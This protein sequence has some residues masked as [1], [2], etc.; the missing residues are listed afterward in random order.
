VKAE[1]LIV[2]AA[3]HGIDLKNIAGAS[4]PTRGPSVRR[5]PRTPAEMKAARGRPQYDTVTGTTTRTF[6]RPP[7]SLAEL[8]QAAQGVPRIPWLAA[9]FA[10]A[11]DRDVYWELHDALT[12]EAVR[13]K[14]Q[15]AWS[16]HIVGVDGLPRFYLLDLA[17]LVLDEEQHAPLFAAA[18]ATNKR[19]SLYA[20]YMHIEEALWS[21][22]IFERFDLLKLRYLSWI[23]TANAMIQRRLSQRGETGEPQ[24]QRA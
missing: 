17:Q 8:G 22:R 1:D 9:R 21:R 10:Y 6:R 4:R 2:L 20:V 7:W 18:P 11:G 12:I 13:L 5:R 15:H 3:A 23:D 14:R 24:E 19:P 16:A